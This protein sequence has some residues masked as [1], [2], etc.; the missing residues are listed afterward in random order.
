MGGAGRPT[1]A[2]LASL[3][4]LARAERQGP[5]GKLGGG[6]CASQSLVRG[7]VSHSFTEG[8]ELWGTVLEK[9]LGD[10]VLCVEGD[11]EFVVGRAGTL[12]SRGRQ[13]LYLF[14]EVLL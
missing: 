4:S 10:G 14:Q 1:L 6:R 2:S 13:V 3:V 8:A 7:G 9:G 5:V 11:R 12:G